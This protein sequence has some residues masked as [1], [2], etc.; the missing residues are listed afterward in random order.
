MKEAKNNYFIKNMSDINNPEA[1]IILLG[2][3]VE[4][5][6]SPLIHNEA[7]KRYNLDYTYYAL[8]VP[9]EELEKVMYQ[10]KK[11]KIRGCNITIPHKV[12]VKK[13]LD[14]ISD[15]ANLIGAVNT[16]VNVNG[17]LYGYNTDGIGFYR[18][19]QN[20][21]IMIKGK[22]IAILGAGG[23]ANSIGIKMALE[24]ADRIDI[25]NR[26]FERANEISTIINKLG[27]ASNTYSL[28]EIVSNYNYNI[29]INCTPMGMY[30][31]I[32]SYIV[33]P[34]IF[35]KTTIIVDIVYNPIVTRFLELARN[36]G[37]KAI[38]GLDML[39]YQGA[40]AFRLW[41][42]TEPNIEIYK[43]ALINKGIISFNN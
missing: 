18:S 12:E 9:R 1:S 5:S 4:H 14:K 8:D 32:D 19:L 20:K 28:K 17:K 41:T 35:D 38:E 11:L 39:L 31:N 36:A 21:G 16:I 37:M 24:R 13:Y 15:E 27:I 30:P 7:F 23:A 6:F 43:E 2:N 33:N 3:P 42:G 25:F 10:I 26:S 34:L 22:N 40:E 29:V